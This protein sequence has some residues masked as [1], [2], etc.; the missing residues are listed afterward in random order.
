[1]SIEGERLDMIPV[2]EDMIT[3]CTFGGEDGKTLFITAG[4]K[5]WSVVIESLEQRCQLVPL[6]KVH[7][8]NLLA[9]STSR[10]PGDD[11]KITS[12]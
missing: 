3:N 5:L 2:P 12:P 10:F 9:V 11:N 7:T 1:V 6:P 8:K 4:A